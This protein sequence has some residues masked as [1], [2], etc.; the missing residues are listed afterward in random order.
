MNLTHRNVTDTAPPSPG[1]SCYF[2]KTVIKYLGMRPRRCLGL[3]RTEIQY[4]EK[5]LQGGAQSWILEGPVPTAVSTGLPLPG[6]V[7]SV[8]P[9]LVL[10]GAGHLEGGR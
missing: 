2:L 7:C 6:F 1:F 5:E 10:P 3:W 8:L 9:P 4:L